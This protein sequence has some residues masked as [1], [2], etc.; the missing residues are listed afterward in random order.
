MTV[1]NLE[2]QEQPLEVYQGE[3]EGD[4][5]M[6]IQ[7]GEGRLYFSEAMTRRIHQA[8]TEILI[9]KGELNY[10]Q[11]ASGDRILAA[12]IGHASRPVLAL[13]CSDA[14]DRDANP[15]GLSLE[16]EG[17]DGP[18]ESYFVGPDLRATLMAALLELQE[19]F[20]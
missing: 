14:A 11:D 6:V 3:L 2:P 16:V 20:A 7:A 15:V 19:R 8:V 17:R 4:W 9:Q 1:P 10:A 12:L 18:I 5:R 13:Y